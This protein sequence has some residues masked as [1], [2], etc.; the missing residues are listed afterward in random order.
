MGAHYCDAGRER[1]SGKLIFPTLGMDR[2][3]V[4]VV[5]P[6]VGRMKG[7]FRISGR[8]AGWVFF[9]KLSNLHQ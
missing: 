1:Q 4:Q 8:P 7:L 9:E 6:R 3:A 5:F 2:T